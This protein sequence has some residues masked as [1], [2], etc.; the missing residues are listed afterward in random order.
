MP[1]HCSK[2][3]PRSWEGGTEWA[4]FHLEMGRARGQKACGPAGEKKAPPKKANCLAWSPRGGPCPAGW[5]KKG[6][7]KLAAR[8]AGRP[9]GR[10]NW[11]KP[12]PCRSK[13]PRPKTSRAPFGPKWRPPKKT[14]T[15]KFSTNHAASKKTVNFYLQ[16]FK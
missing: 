10:P 13:R 14:Q 5:P 2:P 16:E 4:A 12:I 6:A 8:T 9:A 7:P 11:K 3:W 1:G 15:Q